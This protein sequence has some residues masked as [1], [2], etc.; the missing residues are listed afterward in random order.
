MLGTALN[1][2]GYFLSSNAHA[3]VVDAVG[4]EARLEFYTNEGTRGSNVVPNALALTASNAAL[5]TMYGS[6]VLTRA[7]TDAGGV[8]RLDVPGGTVAAAAIH[9]ASATGARKAVVLRDYNPTSDHQYAGLGYAGGALVHQVPTD[10]GAHRFL[11]AY[12]A[13]TSVELARIQRHP[14]SH[15]PQVVVGAAVAASNTAFHVAGNAVVDG[16]LVVT[17]AID[18]SGLTDI[19]RL[20]PAT[21]LIPAALLPSNLVALNS[22]NLVDAAVLPTAYNFQ[23]LR[24]GKNVGIG[25][26]HPQQKLHVAGTTVV[27]PRLGVGTTAPVATLHV[28]QA[29]AVNPAVL[30]ES[31]VVAAPL[32]IDVAGAPVFNISSAGGVGIGTTAAAPGA[33]LHVAGDVRVDGAFVIEA[34]NI[35][36]LDWTD[37]N[38][39]MVYLKKEAVVTNL[40]TEDALVCHAP[41]IL[42]DRLSTPAILATDESDVTFR[43]CGVV[44]DGGLQ[45]AGPVVFQTQPLVVSDARVKTGVTPISD[46]L[47]RLCRLR[48]YTYTKAGKGKEAGL[49]A[50]EVAAVLPEAVGRAVD[51]SLAVS[52]DAV[53]ALLVEAV[54]ELRGLRGSG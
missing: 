23:Y 16:N 36:A 9:A 2:T 46:A 31:D 6:N 17:G 48:G 4:A 15:V 30:I 29:V 47:D 8:P 7:S 52:Y 18:L 12:D 22:S 13:T 35:S 44:V 37:N 28:R 3:L 51:G 49:L 5:Y 11:S 32:R 38:T 39:G 10:G 43:D 25:T 42:T 14:I 26:R 21:A 24:S 20:D 50:Q 54:R 19:V 27:G 45:V 1:A 40:G 33:R 41:L 53:I 34:L